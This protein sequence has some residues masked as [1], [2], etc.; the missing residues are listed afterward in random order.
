EKGKKG[1]KRRREGGNAELAVGWFLGS[2]HVGKINEESLSRWHGEHF[3][4][5]SGDSR[6]GGGHLMVS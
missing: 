2:L 1:K 6:S 4:V 3:C 5:D